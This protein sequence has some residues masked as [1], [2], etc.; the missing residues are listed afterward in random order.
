[1]RSAP[2]GALFFVRPYVDLKQ[3]LAKKIN[4]I[5]LVAACTPVKLDES[6]T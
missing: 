5:A 3:S 4:Q 1:M 2:L 6:S